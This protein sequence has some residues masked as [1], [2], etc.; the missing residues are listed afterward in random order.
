MLSGTADLETLAARAPVM[1]GLGAAPVQLGQVEV[2]QVLYE[3]DSAQRTSL[4]PPGLHPTDPPVV[5]WLLYRCAVS[6][7]GPFAMAQTR[8]ECRSGLRLRAFLIGAVIDNEAARDALQRNWGFVASSGEVSLRRYYDAVETRVAIDGRTALH[9]T[10][11][12]PE[13]LGPH[14]I[15]YVANMH[16]ARTPR[17]IRLVQVEP[18]Y[19]I[20]RAERG[21]SVR[22]GFDGTPWGGPSL[23]PVYPISAALAAADVVLPAIRF[24]CRAD[25]WA[26]EGTEPV[27]ET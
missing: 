20:A 18:R 14:D 21:R 3:I 5:S 13:P 4:L 24:M 15:Q 2:L 6:P 27:E 10:M 19:Q 25:V 16:L 17:G 9:L 26:F 23:R 12:D 7:W 22:H 8:I 1:P 11:T